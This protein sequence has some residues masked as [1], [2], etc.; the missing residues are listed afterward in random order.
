[1]VCR[2]RI[3]NRALF[4]RH[5]RRSIALAA[6]GIKKIFQSSAASQDNQRQQQ[7]DARGYESLLLS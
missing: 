2:D 7:C 3:Y 4:E 1:M 6:K 5:H